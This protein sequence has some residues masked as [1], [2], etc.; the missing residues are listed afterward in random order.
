MFGLLDSRYGVWERLKS[1]G[2]SGLN[3]RLNGVMLPRCEETLPDEGSLDSAVLVLRN[4]GRWMVFL[5]VKISD[6]RH[7]RLAC[8]SLQCYVL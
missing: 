3:W 1:W 5:R 8:K 6:N 4:V 7:V 2:L